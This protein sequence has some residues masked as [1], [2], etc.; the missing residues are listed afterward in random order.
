MNVGHYSAHCLPDLEV[1][2]SNAR[3]IGRLQDA[4]VIEMMMGV[5]RSA[6]KF[7][8]D[9]RLLLKEMAAGSAGPLG[10][11]KLPYQTI[12]IETPLMCDPSQLVE[13]AGACDKTIVVA[14]QHVD[15]E[16][17]VVSCVN[18][19]LVKDYGWRW[20][21]GV[22]CGALS[23]RHRDEAI[24]PEDGAAVSGPLAGVTVRVAPALPDSMRAY[25]MAAGV[26]DVV[27]EKVLRGLYQ[28]IVSECQAVVA[29]LWSLEQ[30]RTTVERQPAPAALNKKRRA[31]GSAEFD[32]YHV[33]TIEPR[34]DH[35]P[36]GVRYEDRLSPR[37]HQRRGH[38]RHFKSG[39]RVWVRECVINE[40]VGGAIW[41][42]YKV[43]S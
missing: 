9:V 21:P 25:A 7:A 38:W 33:V 11:L 19:L 20:G 40:G 18:R 35:A 3:Q 27:D 32:E 39:A 36:T 13:G 30:R 34:H 43:R 24:V 8:I 31:R 29:L 15:G 2:L 5:L 23:A 12:V 6:P 1:C 26:T 14:Q 41:K 10:S 42:D 37:E 16:G 4:R 17:I 22:S 28:D